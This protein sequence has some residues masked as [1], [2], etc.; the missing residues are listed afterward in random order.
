MTDKSRE[1][2]EGVGMGV[3]SL[4]DDCFN[5]FKREW[6][7]EDN[8]DS[9]FSDMVCTVYPIKNATRLIV[10]KCNKFDEKKLTRKRFEE[11]ERKEKGEK[12][13]G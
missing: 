12:T 2:G 7:R 8:L 3:E 6:E 13:G 11:M 4:C 1:K 10:T 5:C 9:V